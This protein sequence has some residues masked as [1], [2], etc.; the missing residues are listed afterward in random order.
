MD[1]NE[2]KNIAAQ[3]RK[4]NGEYAIEVGKRMNEGN[5]LMNQQVIK[6]LCPEK[7][8]QL[9]EI[10]MG[11]G[12]FVKEIVNLQPEISYAGCDFSEIMVAESI[13]NNRD[14]VL[15]NKADFSCACADNMP[16]QNNRFDKVFTLNTIYFWEDVKLVLAEIKRVLKANGLLFIGIRPKEIMDHFPIT[17]Y[18]FNTFSESDLVDLL[19]AN[20]FEVLESTKRDEEDL[21]FF[22][23]KLK[24]EFLIVK[25]KLL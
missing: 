23:E 17:Q 13:E 7:N 4:P 2:L 15:A 12:F 16:Y 5:L 24:N 1:E 20:G 18:G 6:M 9:L 25:A 19:K 8:D 22:G 10:G 11:N 3:L 21:E 14:L